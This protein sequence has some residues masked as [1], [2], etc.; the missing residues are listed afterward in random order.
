MT[1]LIIKQIRLIGIRL[2]RFL[3]VQHNYNNKKKN[4]VDFTII[5]KLSLNNY[6]PPNLKY[7]NIQPCFLIQKNQFIS[8]YNTLGYLEA[9]TSNSLE[10]VKFKIKKYISKQILVISNH[11]C[12]TI[13]K[14]KIRK[15]KL[16]DFITTNQNLNKIGKI[17]IENDK[18]FT[19]Q[20]GRPYFFPNCKKEELNR[21]TNLE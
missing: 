12:L 4:C 20:K 9:I 19:I 15:K 16:N 14:E 2:K 17:I 10:I 5:E 7:K 13:K 11:D 18:F 1:Y 8:N 21:N 3:L 6:I